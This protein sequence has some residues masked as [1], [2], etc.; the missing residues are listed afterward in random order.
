MPHQLDAEVELRGNGDQLPC[1]H[2]YEAGSEADVHKVTAVRAG[3]ESV[4]SRN[5]RP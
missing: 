4:G 3:T 5:S 2:I 1:V